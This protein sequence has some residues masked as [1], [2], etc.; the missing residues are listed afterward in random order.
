MRIAIAALVALAST[1][2]VPSGAVRAEPLNYD[3]AYLSHQQV[4]VDGE[5]FRNS[6]LGAY[7][8]LGKHLHVF[9][10]YGDA[11]AYGNPAWKNSRALR[12]GLG[13]RV[14]LGDDT[15]IALEGAVVC[16]RFDRPTGERVEDTGVAAIAEIRHRFLPW[17]EGIA[18]IS[19]SDVLGRR[20][21]EFVAGPVFHVNDLLAL[22]ALYRRNEGHSGVE[23]T[24]RWY[25]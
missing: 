24:A 14:N 20:S 2:L 17:M 9:G 5:S 4:H 22:G 3:Y 7:Y 25:Y 16:A 23:V 19:R 12:A 21:G 18:S 15:L 8:E 1:A 11:G 10:S 6:T 13:A